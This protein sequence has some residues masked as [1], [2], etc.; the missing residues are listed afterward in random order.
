MV[1]LLAFLLLM[2]VFRSLL[3]PLTASVMN[4]L[5]VGAALGA[6]NAVFNLGW[7]SS[8][9]GLSGTGPIDA[10]IPVLLFSVLFGLSMDY[11]VYLVSRIQE[12]WHHLH[13][14]QTSELAALGGRAAR[15]NHQAVTTG[16]IERERGP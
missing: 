6:L 15:R 13:H 7:G 10:F 12:E 9:F 14:T 4:L 11:E 16:D 1:V 5:S 2:T 3:I 8:I